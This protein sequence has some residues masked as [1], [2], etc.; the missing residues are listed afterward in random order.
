[1]VGPGDLDGT[2]GHDGLLLKG[3]A[4]QSLEPPSHAKCVAGDP[5]SGIGGE[6]GDGAGDV[7]RLGH[8]LQRLHAEREVPAGLGPGE[9]RHV[10]LHHPG[11]NG[12]HPHAPRP[13][14]QGEVLDQRVDRTLGRRVGRQV[15]HRRVRRERGGED[16]A[17][18]LLPDRQQLLDQEVGG[19]H[20]D[21]ELRVEVLDRRL[22]DRG[23]RGDAG[24]GDQDVQTVADDLPHLGG[25]PVRPPGLGQVGPD[26]F[27]PP[28]R[29]LDLVHDRARLG[30]VAAI[31]DEHLRASRGERQGG[32]TAD[33]ARGAG[34][35]RGL[36]VAGVS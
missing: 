34:D 4:G 18:A 17:G 20:V 15:P 36:P 26:G 9:A 12:V 11:C 23:R 6:E 16:D 28:A 22:F 25:E 5:T 13:E 10:G 27:G 32:G 21:G 8:A 33:A 35:E 30:G 19:T 1:M 7:V 2:L 29:G 31:M 3:S 24:I 14:D